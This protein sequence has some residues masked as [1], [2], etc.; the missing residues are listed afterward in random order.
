MSKGFAIDFWDL[1]QM[2]RCPQHISDRMHLVSREIGSPM[3][4][5][6]TERVPYSSRVFDFDDICGASYGE[7]PLTYQYELTA[8]GGKG[9][10][11]AQDAFTRLRQLLRWKGRRDLYDDAFPDYI[12]EVRAPS[13]RMEHPQNGIYLITIMFQAN[14]GMLPVT[15]PSE[16]LLRLQNAQF[17]DLFSSGFVTGADAAIILQAAENI[18]AGKE[19]GLTPEQENL[20]DADRDGAITTADAVLVTEFI[21]ATAAGS[22]ENSAAGWYA[23]LRRYFRLQEAV[24]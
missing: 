17:P 3:K 21:A 6:H 20:A 2:Y 19:S 15:L 22:Y 10:K 23:F 12:F 16:H 18:A 7:R 4:D 1:R 24:Y 8:F 14:P 11:Q 13:V 9:R 5:D